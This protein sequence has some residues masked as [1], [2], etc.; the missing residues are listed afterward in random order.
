PPNVTVDVGEVVTL[1]L[2]LQNVGSADTANLQATLQA[3]GG[4]TSPS[5]PQNYGALAYGGAAVARPFTFTATGAN[6]GAVLATLQLQ[7]GANNLGTVAFVFKFP[8]TI[9]FTNPA[10]IAIPDHG[11]ATPYPSTINV[12]GVTGKVSKATV[13]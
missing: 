2:A 9:A 13:T 4:V 11:G 12:T 6:G 3:T 5:G 10:A 8:A 1:S 7:D